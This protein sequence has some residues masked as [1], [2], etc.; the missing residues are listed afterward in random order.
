MDFLVHVLVAQ[1]VIAEPDERSSAFLPELAPFFESE[2]F[3]HAALLQGDFFPRNVTKACKGRG[4]GFNAQVVAGSD[5]NRP[6]KVIMT[7]GV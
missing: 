5:D 2:A 4:D 3:G 7:M 6:A 1:D